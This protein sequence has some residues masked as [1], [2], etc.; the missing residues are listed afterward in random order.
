[1]RVDTLQNLKIKPF[2]GLNSNHNEFNLICKKIIILETLNC[3]IGAKDQSIS[4]TLDANSM[5][6]S[7]IRLVPSPRNQAYSKVNKGKGINILLPII[8]VRI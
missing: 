2:K 5:C 1:M 3:S 4:Y 8:C 7:E 6:T